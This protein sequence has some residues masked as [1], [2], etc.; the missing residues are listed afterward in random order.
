VEL[1]KA[2]ESCGANRTIDGVTVGTLE[3]RGVAARALFDYIVDDSQHY[4]WYAAWRSGSSAS[5]RGRKG[6][7][8]RCIAHQSVNCVCDFTWS[9][10]LHLTMG[11]IPTQ[12]TDVVLACTV[13]A[14]C[15]LLHSTILTP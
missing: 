8:D 7:V 2:C 6:W 11:R 5:S 13:P 1:S 4:F 12:T 14:E 9:C 3:R 10:S 15:S